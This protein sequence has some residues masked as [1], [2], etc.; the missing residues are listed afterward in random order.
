MF[1][2]YNFD[3]LENMG[4][5]K[6]IFNIVIDDCFKISGCK[7]LESFNKELVVKMPSIPN[8]SGAGY[9]KV[10]DSAQNRIFNEIISD[11]NL[12]QKKVIHKTPEKLKYTVNVHYMGTPNLKAFCSLNIGDYVI[13]GIRILEN[14]SNNLFVSMPGIKTDKLNDEG[15]TIYEYVANPVTKDFYKELNKSI[16]SV[17]DELCLRKEPNEIALLKKTIV[18]YSYMLDKLNNVTIPDFMKELKNVTADDYEGLYILIG[19]ATIQSRLIQDA[20]NVAR[21]RIEDIKNQMRSNGVIDESLS[22]Y[23]GLFKDIGETGMGLA[24]TQ[25]KLFYENLENNRSKNI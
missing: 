13:N 23:D 21:S 19:E 12:D 6:A 18:E 25:R 8:Q 16:L 24:P 4:N 20:I 2:E 11:Y 5:L 10:S 17:Y 7:I 15:K 22:N 9:A 3:K 1:Y 14:K